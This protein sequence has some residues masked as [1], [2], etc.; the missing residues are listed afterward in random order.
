MLLTEA[1]VSMSKRIEKKAEMWKKTRE[2]RGSTSKQVHNS[3]RALQLPLL[4]TGTG[5]VMD[6]V[7]IV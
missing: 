1:A 2:D 3:R 5:S 6:V 4:Q 7:E